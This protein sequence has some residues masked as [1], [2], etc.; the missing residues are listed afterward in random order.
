MADSSAIKVYGSELL[1]E[2]YRSLIEVLGS[3]A[4]SPRA[5]RARFCKEESSLRIATD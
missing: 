4:Y 1:I 2:A 3:P 5:V